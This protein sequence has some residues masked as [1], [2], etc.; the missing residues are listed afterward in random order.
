MPQTSK[1]KCRVKLA[2]AAAASRW[3]KKSTTNCIHTQQEPSEVIMEPCINNDDGQYV[4]ERSN[5]DQG[6]EPELA[7]TSDVV[8]DDGT[9]K[10][11]VDVASSK[12]RK[13]RS[14]LGVKRIGGSSTSDVVMDDGTD[15]QRVDVASANVR[16][17]RTDLGVKRNG[18]SSTSD[19]VMP[20]DDGT[21]ERRVDVA[22][23][24]VK[25]RRSDLGVKRNGGASQAAMKY[26]SKYTSEL[27][28][29]RCGSCLREDSS[30][31]FIELSKVK[32]AG[33]INYLRKMKTYNL[34]QLRRPDS[35][36]YDK[37]FSNAY[38][39]FVD[40]DGI[41]RS[42][43]FICLDCYKDLRKVNRFFFCKLKIIFN[44]ASY[45]LF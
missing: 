33:I 10:Q 19:V 37:I 43:R 8:M 18:G 15:K 6:Q 3:D 9:N 38:Q 1:V 13:R 17:R 26:G 36:V 21:N 42:S 22:S 7:D 40:D 12:V 29:L 4:A 45:I 24:T 28:F 34:M 27:R 14:D 44:C 39:D 41:F 31:K 30:S 11:C 32:E 5:F 2:T 16:K 23:P 20:L 35:T 25:K